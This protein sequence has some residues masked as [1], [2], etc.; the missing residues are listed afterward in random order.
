M[1]QQYL[2]IKAQHPDLLVF[3]RM[4]DFYELFYDDAKKA[5]ALLDIT[6]TAR[7]KS[8]GQSI[9][10]AGVPY[11]AAESYLG[12][13]V[14]QGE[15]VAVCEQIGDPATSKGPV[16]REVV[17]IVT[18][19]TVSDEAFL[20]SQADN[21]LAALLQHDKQFSLAYLDI[22][23]GR[24]AASMLESTTACAAE[25]QRLR[26]AE[27]LLHELQEASLPISRQTLSQT[28]RS[29]QRRGPWEFEA[30]TAFRLLCDQFATRDLNGFGIDLQQHSALIQA[31][32]AVLS[33]AQHTQRAALPHITR[34]EILRSDDGLRMDAATRRNLEIDQNIS[35][36][37]S[38]T[39]AA[40]LD[41]TRTAMGGRLL[42]R[43]LH[44]PLA[45]ITAIENRQRAIAT[46]LTADTLETLQECLQQIGDVE[47]IL[48]RVA[49]RSARP[50]DLAKLAQALQILPGLRSL[51]PT[52]D[53]LL[54][55]LL[56]EL[57]EFPALA[58]ELERA[59]VDNPPMVMR[60]GGV[61]AS[62]YDKELDELRSISENASDYLLSIEQREREQTGI[63]TLKVGYNRVHGYY[64]EISRAQ[65]EQA[66]DRYVRRQTLKNAERFITPELKEFEDRALSSK[67]RALAR[68]KALYEQL[69]DRLNQDLTELQE[70]ARAVATVDVL[71]NLAER[72][73]A[74][75]LCR[76]AFSESSRLM[77]E[78]GRHLVVEQASEAPFVANDLS[79]HDARRMLVI[80]GPNM[81]GKSTYMR[82]TAIVVLL[83]HIGCYVPAS[84]VELGLFDQIFTRIG[85]SDD[86]AGGRSTF[87]VE[88]T[89]AANILNNASERSLVLMDEIG[90]GTST[91]DGLALAYACAV[92]LTKTLRA[93]T[94]FATHYFEL[95][96][97][98]EEFDAVSNVHLDAT[99][100]DDSIV[101]LH[102]VQPGPANQSYGIHVAK[103]AG[104]PT[105]VVQMA[106]HKLASLETLALGQA[107]TDKPQQAELF[108]SDERSAESTAALYLL[109][110]LRD[111]VLPDD[112]S[113][114]QALE[115]LYNLRQRLKQL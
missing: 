115:F 95:T 101:F 10:M 34:L 5:A 111:S 3:Y 114:R 18:P 25:L 85:S 54:D 109:E 4:G 39:I 23:S 33:Y 62:S 16:D 68:E 20:D 26:P 22:S 13:L 61:I 28:C 98:E 75:N 103:L 99:E 15:S 24:F 108:G 70:S 105:G 74:L 79:L 92:E 30:D 106:R 31:A 8:N 56:V 11:H 55:E 58:D 60:D 50:R 21:L 2:K 91:F 64:I 35:G 32:G 80:T 52:D 102:S 65:S 88:M 41:G 84:K 93:Y 112:M 48:A 77:I 36:G 83:A 45:N 67:A 107:A 27:L 19:G 40:V 43:W 38:N 7:G 90:R 44:R 59:L 1:M 53:G 66:P 69:L 87:M 72:A 63:S 82:Q 6:L 89:E 57:G 47:R 76:P 113:P 14:R 37:T 104:I 94:L 73:V 97:L 100:F 12:R 96:A 78:Q 17:R 71:A 9:P 110:E 49:L 81:G 42:R 46:L 86:I 51:L 29:V